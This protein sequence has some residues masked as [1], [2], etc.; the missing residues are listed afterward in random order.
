M[1]TLPGIAQLRARKRELLVES[2]LN[3]QV[4]RVEAEALRLQVD[5]VRAT[6]A[7]G[8]A[9][10]QWAAPVAGFLLARR[11]DKS[12]GLLAKGSMLAGALGSAWKLFQTFRSSRAASPAGVAPRGGGADGPESHAKA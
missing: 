6:C 4:L 3:R 2:E 7:R 8:R 1:D 5:Q 12:G 11:F 9:V 10:W